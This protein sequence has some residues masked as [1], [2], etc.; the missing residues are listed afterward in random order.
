MK[1]QEEQSIILDPNPL[2]PFKVLYDLPEKTWLVV[3]IGGRGGAKSFEVS[4]FLT[5]QSVIEEKRCAVLRDEQ[6]TIAQSI[7][8]EIKQRFEELNHATGNVYKRRYEMQEKGLKDRLKGSMAIFPKGFKTSNTGK[9]TGLKSIAAVDIALVE[10]FED[11]TDE[12]KFNTFADSIRKEGA[13]IIINSNVPNRHHW[14]IRRYFNLVESTDYPGYY[15]LQAKQIP[16]VVYIFT[17][18]TKN[19]ELSE[20]AIERYKA[21]GNPNS[22][23]YNLEHFCTDVL[24]L[25]PEGAKGRI[26]PGMMPVTNE[27]YQSLPYPRFFG[28]D[29]GFGGDPLALVEMKEHNMKLWCKERIYE[30]GLTNTVLIRRLRD[31]GITGADTI[32]ADSAEPKSI[33]ELQD[34]GFNVVPAIKG[35]DSVRIGIKTVQGLTLYATEE[36]N[37]LWMENREYKWKLAKDGVTTTTETVGPDHLK[38]GIRYGYVTRKIKGAHWEIK[39][40]N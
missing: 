5:I 4:K 33:Q 18:F 13:F 9:K 31:M 10:E 29:F 21:Y 15:E 28:L 39:K 22:E 32:Y 8:H 36:S 40:R 19:T 14:F 30:Q 1:Q 27:F 23:M 37:N 35:P 17:D 2:E 11:I 16:G 20:N 25:V 26:Y 7:L 38:D 12:G 24:G 34:A 6:T 3:C